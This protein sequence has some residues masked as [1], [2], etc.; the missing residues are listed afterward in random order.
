MSERWGASDRGQ[1]LLISGLLIAVLFVGLAVVVNSAIYAENRASRET[2]KSSEALLDHPVTQD[3]LSR[4][5][6]DVNYG[7]DTAGYAER[8]RNVS[9]NVTDWESRM[10]AKR[11]AEGTLFGLKEV[12]ITNGTRITQDVSREFRPHGGAYLD[13]SLLSTYLDPLGLTDRMSWLVA[14]DVRS[15]GYRATVDRSSLKDTTTGL[16]DIVGFVLNGND[17]FGVVFNETSGFRTV[18]LV[19]LVESGDEN[20]VAA[21]VTRSNA[22]SEEYV[23]HCRVEAATATV[24]FDENELEGNGTTVDCPAMSFTESLGQHDVYYV[25]SNNVEGTYDLIV[26]KR[27]STFDQEVDEKYDNN[28]LDTLLDLSCLLLCDTTVYEDPGEGNP[29]TTWA[30][31]NSTV[32]VTYRDDR[33]H[34]TR[35]VPVPAES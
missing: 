23:G 3:R 8:T 14:P 4:A 29:F 24:R 2:T 11:A 1:M 5:I 31:Y 33:V 6:H 25:G 15:R 19:E 7:S 16:D 30:V 18:Y 12:E 20:D 13:E 22:T 21:V 34:F 26:D 28:L 35:N 17:P 27:K 9:D 10:R 32:E